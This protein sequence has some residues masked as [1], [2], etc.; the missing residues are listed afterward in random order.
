MNS[1][2]PDLRCYHHPEREA[3]SQCDRCGDY[4][5]GQCAGEHDEEYL[6]PRCLRHFKRAQLPVGSG[7]F[8]I[9]N[10]IGAVLFFPFFIG[11]VIIFSNADYSYAGEFLAA[12][13]FLM[14]GGQFVFTGLG[15]WKKTKGCD[16]RARTLLHS[17]C[18]ESIA[19]LI[20]C[21]IV[22]VW[23][24]IDFVGMESPSLFHLC[25][26]P[27]MLLAGTMLVWSAIASVRAVAGGVRPIW[28]AV[29]SFVST[30]VGILIF[31]FFGVVHGNLL[32]LW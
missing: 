3:T 14:L 28:F 18:L 16:I 6:C 21:I 23:I 7:K 13:P 10:L 8:A 22:T 5:C 2:A 31:G 32:G 4:L 12:V 1:T 20:G 9:L 30:L 27:L 17:I 11:A 25:T 15:A 26:L 19:G 29:F 24:S